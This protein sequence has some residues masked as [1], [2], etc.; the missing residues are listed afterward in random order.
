M[1]SRSVIS[2][3]AGCAGVH[4]GGCWKTTSSSPATWTDEAG[5]SADDVLALESLLDL[6]DDELLDLLLARKEPAGTLDDNAV[7]TVL[8]GLRS[9]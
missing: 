7:R 6:P 3:G 5:L 2:N 1:P 8:D 4:A 9:V